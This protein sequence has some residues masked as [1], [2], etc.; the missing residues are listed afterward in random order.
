MKLIKTNKVKEYELRSGKTIRAPFFFFGLF[1]VYGK[2]ANDFLFLR[3][4]WK[5][6]EDEIKRGFTKSNAFEFPAPYAITTGRYGQFLK[7]ITKDKNNVIFVDSGGYQLAERKVKLK[8]MIQ[9]QVF[10]IQMKFNADLAPTLDL[11]I[12]SGFKTE[13]KAL[14]LEEIVANR[15]K[16]TLDNIE[17][18]FEL[19]K[20]HPEAKIDLLPVIL[21]PSMNDCAHGNPALESNANLLYKY[22]KKLQKIVTNAT[23]N[24]DEEFNQFATGFPA[25]AVQRSIDQALLTFNFENYT[26]LNFKALYLIKK[27]FNNPFLH[28]F[29]F[30]HSLLGLLFYLFDVTTLDSTSYAMDAR[31]AR[32]YIKRKLN[33]ALSLD[34]IQRNLEKKCNTKREK[35]LYLE[36]FRKSFECDC[37]VCRKFSDD[38]FEKLY[39]LYSNDYT[40]FECE[41]FEDK[42]SRTRLSHTYTAYHN[43]R[44]AQMTLDEIKKAFE[45]GKEAELTLKYL[46]KTTK[47]NLAL[48]K[49]YLE[50]FKYICEVKD[51]PY[52]DLVKQ[53]DTSLMRYF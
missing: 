7:E 47:D 14:S 48:R 49:E 11:P 29:G 43:L 52:A 36:K 26:L 18:A 1:T 44:M 12:K 46:L 45:A 13:K 38:L 25:N 41:E 30:G 24:A 51:Y 5:K 15:I 42:V 50:V 31:F 9:S 53:Y 23:K 8:K 22:I 6:A 20:V 19:C 37:Y 33:K 40:K 16:T 28:V 35:T 39:S 27:M 34:L 3:P 32:Y 10:K 4:Q 17:K 21:V 2:Q